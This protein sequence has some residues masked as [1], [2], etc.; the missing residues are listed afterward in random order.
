MDNEI[1]TVERILDPAF[2][3]I[4]EDIRFHG[5]VT[6]VFRDGRV[7]RAEQK[8]KIV[9]QDQDGQVMEYEIVLLKPE[10]DNDGG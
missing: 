3:R 2:Q 5:E 10:E 9:D 7:I 4:F 1:I 6:L 8:Q